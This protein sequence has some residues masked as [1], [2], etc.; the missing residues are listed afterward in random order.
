MNQIETARNPRRTRLW[1]SALVIITV[2]VASVFL[3]YRFNPVSAAIRRADT[4]FKKA[5][6]SLDSEAIR[7]WALDCIRNQS[8]KRQISDSMPKEL[9][10]LYG[11]RP[12]VSIDGSTL[13][14]FWGG[15]FFGWSFRIG[16]TNDVVPYISGNPEFPYNFEWRPGIYYT[17]EAA[18]KLQ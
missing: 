13:Y 14:L 9:R 12:Y 4:G 5:T 6:N 16:N 10:E 2:L 7:A 15:G 3:F 17:R 1:V 11:S 8:S 18:W